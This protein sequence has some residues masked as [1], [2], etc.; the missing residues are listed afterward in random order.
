MTALVDV[1][2]Y[3]QTREKARRIPRIPRRIQELLVSISEDI[4]FVRDAN[5]PT[6]CQRRGVRGVRDFSSEESTLLEI[7]P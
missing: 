1:V 6:V 5:T 4:S 7:R 3:M 2:L